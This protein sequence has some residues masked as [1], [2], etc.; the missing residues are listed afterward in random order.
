MQN[1][2]RSRRLRTRVV[3]LLVAT[4]VSLTTVSA[5]VQRPL[6]PVAPPVSPPATR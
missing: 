3:V 5:R 4:T 2:R 6:G 1:M